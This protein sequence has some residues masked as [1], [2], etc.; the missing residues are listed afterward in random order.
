MEVSGH[1]LRIE[2]CTLLR[3]GVAG[4]SNLRSAPSVKTISLLEGGRDLDRW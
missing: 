3:L 2:T 1:C 4:R